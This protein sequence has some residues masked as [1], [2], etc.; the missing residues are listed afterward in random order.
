MMR[1][2]LASLI[3]LAPALPTHAEVILACTFPTLPSVVMR[4]PDSLEA[5]KTMEVGAR[6]PVALLEG[7]G[8]GR[9]M[10]ASV[11]GFDFRYSP[12][13]STLDVEKNGE[14]LL[15]EPGNCVT[16]GG[17]VNKVPLQ[18]TVPSEEPIEPTTGATP[19][20]EGQPA[21]LGKWVI[22]EDKSAFDDSR[23]VT[24]SLESSEAIRGQFGSPGPAMLYLR[25]M[26]NTTVAY[27]WLNDLF[28]S[29]IEGFGMV[30]YRIDE[31]QATTLRMSTSTDNKALGLWDGGKSI[32]FIKA[33]LGGKKIV[34]RATPF[35][36]SPVEFGFDLTGLETAIAPLKE[37]CAW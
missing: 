27:L 14:A 29:D 15:S 30:D 21:K 8:A 35:N 3:C 10:S 1:P 2:L 16:I 5:Q 7:Q 20:V 36:D 26:E 11:D 24:L 37:A 17:P 33:L 9:L 22:S 34:L 19:V 13:N 6:P 4:F 12:A 18:I 31:Q 23:T 32:P 28:L 25:C